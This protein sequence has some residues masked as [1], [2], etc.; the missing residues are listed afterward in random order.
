M[1]K[2]FHNQGN[3]FLNL[4]HNFIS[5]RDIYVIEDGIPIPFPVEQHCEK[6]FPKW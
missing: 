6:T 3:A 5:H 2:M 4:G 1:V